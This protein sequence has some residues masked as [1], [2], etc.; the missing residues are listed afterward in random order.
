MAL[1]TYS[2]FDFVPF[3]G[4]MLLHKL[5]FNSSQDSLL[6]SGLL[7]D[8]VLGGRGAGEGCPPPLPQHDITKSVH[9]PANG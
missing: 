3:W 4:S 6:C 7:G 5:K 8:K 1:L 2:D 9:C